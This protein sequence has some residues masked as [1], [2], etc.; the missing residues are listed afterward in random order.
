MSRLHGLDLW[1][2]RQSCISRAR[3]ADTSGLGLKFLIVKEVDP[4]NLVALVIRLR[5]CCGLAADCNSDDRGSNISV[6]GSYLTHRE[7]QY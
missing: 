2:S 1:A 4:S 6:P 3:R 5:L 7:H